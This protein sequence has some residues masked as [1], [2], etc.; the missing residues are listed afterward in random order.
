MRDQWIKANLKQVQEGRIDLFKLILCIGR[1]VQAQ[2]TSPRWCLWAGIAAWTG[3]VMPSWGVL[4]TWDESEVTR[5]TSAGSDFIQVQRAY[6]WLCNK[7]TAAGEFQ[8]KE[9][10]PVEKER[11]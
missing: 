9:R 3:G 2:A 6:A 7:E 5:S 8:P 11:F 4:P 10:F 1:G